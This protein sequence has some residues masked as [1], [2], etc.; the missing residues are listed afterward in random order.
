MERAAVIRRQQVSGPTAILFLEQVWNRDLSAYDPDGPLPD[1]DPDLAEPNIVQGRVERLRGPDGDGQPSGGA[2]AE[3]K[4]LSIRELMIEVTEPSLVRRHPGAGGQPDRHGGR[5]CGRPTGSSWCRTSPRAASTSSPTP[6]CPSSRSGT[7]SAPTTRARRCATIWACPRRARPGRSDRRRR[8]PHVTAD[9]GAARRPRPG[10]RQL[11]LRPP[12]R[13]S[14]NTIDLAQT[15]ERLGYRRYWFAEHHLNPGVAGSSPA[16]LIAM[17]AAATEHIRLGSGGVQSGHRTA[18]SVVEEFGLLDAMYPGRI[19]L[20]IGRSGGR[21]FL[22]DR[23]AA[24]S[25][26]TEG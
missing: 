9:A 11:G 13:P 10:A 19:D 16:L 7:A 6:W 12:R 23:L 24:S 5:G 21:N 18:L 15:A 22:R 3:A 1:I 20:G 8:E 4:Y 25:N 17:V 14:R 26:A 2:L